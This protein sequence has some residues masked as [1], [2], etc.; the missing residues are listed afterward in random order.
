MFLRRFVAWVLGPVS[1]IFFP[2][3]CCSLPYVCDVLYFPTRSCLLVWLAAGLW[4]PLLFGVLAPPDDPVYL[5]WWHLLDALVRISP[6]VADAY[7]FICGL[8]VTFFFFFS[9]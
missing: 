3:F 5:V 9:Q 2:L 7:R 8:L 1:V 6:V 4:T